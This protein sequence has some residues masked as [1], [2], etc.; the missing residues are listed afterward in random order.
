MFTC[1]ATI[2]TNF[3][4]CCAVNYYPTIALSKIWTLRNGF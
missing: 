1:L 2:S 4:K 3:L